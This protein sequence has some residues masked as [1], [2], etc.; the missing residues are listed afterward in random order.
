M[1]TVLLDA[2]KKRR[3]VRKFTDQPVTDEQVR[4]LGDLVPGRVVDQRGHDLDHEEHPLDG[5]AP[6]ERVDERRH[7][8]RVH[9]ADREPNADP[10]KSAE[11]RGQKDQEHGVLANECQP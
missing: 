5:P 4:T 6:D 8:G 2:I 10:A 1:D 11:D 3:T 9:E 7:G